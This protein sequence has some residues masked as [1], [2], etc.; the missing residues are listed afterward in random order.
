MEVLTDLIKA[1]TALGTWGVVAGALWKVADKLDS[2]APESARETAKSLLH[3]GRIQRGMSTW[4]QAFQDML[5]LVFGTRHWSWRCFLQSCRASLLVILCGYLVLGIFKADLLLKGFVS[6]GWIGHAIDAWS[7]VWNLVID[8]LAL[9][10]TRGFV[11]LMT[12]HECRRNNTSLVI[13]LACTHWMLAFLLVAIGLRVS[14]LLLIEIHSFVGDVRDFEPRPRDLIHFLG[15]T[16]QLLTLRFPEPAWWVFVPLVWSTFFTVFWLLLYAAARP[17]LGL[18]SHAET[19]MKFIRKYVA[20][21]EAKP[22]HAVAV[23]IIAVWSVIYFIVLLPLSWALLSYT[24]EPSL[25]I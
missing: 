11:G 16:W 7:V 2:I 14:N 9:G 13:L 5:A 10:I 22:F 20:D 21:V 8:F 18:A 4:A 3:P 6:G 17:M 1:V 15:T 25:A 23:A 24:K 12:A 19:T